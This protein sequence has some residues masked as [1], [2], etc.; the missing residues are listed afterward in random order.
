MI[1][2]KSLKSAPQQAWVWTIVGDADLKVFDRRLT[3]S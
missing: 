2:L 1:R 3:E